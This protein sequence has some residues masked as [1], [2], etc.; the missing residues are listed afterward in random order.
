MNEA[1]TVWDNGPSPFRS[2]FATE[3]TFMEYDRIEGDL[4]DA[5]ALL[6]LALLGEE[7]T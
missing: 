6:S 4:I 5:W 7:P 1:M 2:G 3:A